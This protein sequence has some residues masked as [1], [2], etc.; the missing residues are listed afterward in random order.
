MHFTF[1]LYNLGLPKKKNIKLNFFGT[2]KRQ[3][4]TYIYKAIIKL[5]RDGLNIPYN[6][7]IYTIFYLTSLTFNENHL[8]IRLFKEIVKKEE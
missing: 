8:K 3:L 2:I 5:F 6:K 4:F 7:L 1:L